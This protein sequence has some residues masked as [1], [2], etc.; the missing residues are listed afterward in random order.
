MELRETFGASA[1]ARGLEARSGY[2]S[3]GSDLS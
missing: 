1:P 3:P 2:D